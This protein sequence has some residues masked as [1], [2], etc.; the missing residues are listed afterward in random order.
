MNPE[1]IAAHPRAQRVT[2]VFAS[3]LLL[4]SISQSALS[5]PAAPEPQTATPQAAEPL[6]ERNGGRPEAPPPPPAVMPAPVA[7]VVSM[8]AP[9]PDPRV[10]LRPGR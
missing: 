6:S 1:S 4:L 9:N 7:P 3:A 2:S 8:T 5:A 10:G